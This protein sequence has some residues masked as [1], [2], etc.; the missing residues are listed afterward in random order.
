MQDA[1]NDSAK[2]T[3]TESGMFLSEFGSKDLF[4]LCE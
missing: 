2:N 3:K 1:Y 4:P